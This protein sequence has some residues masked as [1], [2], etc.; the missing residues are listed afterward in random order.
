MPAVPRLAPLV[1]LVA[2]T[3]AA[4]DTS[5]LDPDLQPTPTPVPGAVDTLATVHVPARATYLRTNEDPDALDAVP[6]DLAALGVAPGQTLGFF[7]SGYAI[8]DPTR[9]SESRSRVVG[10]VFSQTSTLA[11]STE[12]ARV[13]GAVAAA[14]IDFPT[15]PTALGGLPTDIAEDVLASR[16]SVVVPPGARYLFLSVADVYYSD[17]QDLGA[18]LQLTLLRRR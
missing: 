18:G 2:L 4:C 11:P 12:R 9:P 17:N 3:L 7:V 13:T 8:L 1:V 16:S 14:G 15:E 5:G 10:G 6:V